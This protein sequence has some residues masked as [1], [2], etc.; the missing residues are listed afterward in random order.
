ML[1]PTQP[2]SSNSD[3]LSERAFERADVDLIGRV[4]VISVHDAITTGGVLA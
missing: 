1:S 3:K 2:G 4:D